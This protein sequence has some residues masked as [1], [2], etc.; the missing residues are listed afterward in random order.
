MKKIILGLVVAFGITFAFSGVGYAFNP[1]E[2]A[3]DLSSEAQ[4]QS[5]ACANQQDIV[6]GDGVLLRVVN[7]IAVIAGVAAVFVIIFAGI[8]FILANGDPKKVT[9]ARNT[10]LIALAG[11]VV[12]AVSRV[13]VGFVINSL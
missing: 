11:L 1:L 8:Q 4:G 7:I 2:D 5:P 6:G 13:I 9:T 10:I 3:C 12:I